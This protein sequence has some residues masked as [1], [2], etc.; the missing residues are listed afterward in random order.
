MRRRRKNHKEGTLSLG[1]GDFCICSNLANNSRSCSPSFCLQL[2]NKSSPLALL[3]QTCSAI[4]ADTTNP[5]LLAANIEKS[6]KQ[7]PKGGTAGGGLGGGGLGTLDSSS[8]N[9]A[10][11]KSSPVSSH[12]SSVSTGSVEQQ[13]LP[14]AHSKTPSTFK[15]YEANNNDCGATNLSSNSNSINNNNMGNQRVKTPKANVAPANGQQQL[16]QRCDSNQSASS[17]QRESPSNAHPNASASA[18]VSASA[19]LRRTPTTLGPQL[20]GSPV[21]SSAPIRSNSKESA[22][23]HSPS[24]ASS[25]SSRLQEA[26]Y[27]AAKEANY[28]K[29][30]HAA[31]QQANPAAASYYPPGKCQ[32]S[33]Q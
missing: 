6:T 7:L 18:S 24:A 17:S 22:A 21:Q 30:L 5:K 23:L 11:D 8:S 1:N 19:A 4:G 25:S 3:A 28:V 10:R 20:N 27:A 31:S 32:G 12:S 29:A 2:D 26:A 13:Q 15:P 9:S 16:Q 14:M 33:A